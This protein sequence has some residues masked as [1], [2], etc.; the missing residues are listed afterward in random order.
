M[1]EH[2]E[3]MTSKSYSYSKIALISFL[4]ALIAAI[5][6]TISGFG[7][8]LKIWGLGL[9]FK[10]LTWGAY[11]SMFGI[12]ISILGLYFSRPSKNIRGLGY[13]V[14]G[15]LLSIAVTSTALFF[16]NR[17]KSAPPIHDISTDTVKP[18]KFK[19]VLPMRA[20]YPNKSTYAGPKTAA[21][22]H[23]Y[24]PDIKPLYLKQKPSIAYHKALQ[25]AHEMNGGKL[26]RPIPYRAELKQHQQFHGSDLKM[27]L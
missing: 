14:V 22:Q 12:L 25:A 8:N 11:L 3:D 6:F 4:V 13:A 20:K 24:Y 19:A 27:I 10:L 21:L 5:M 23:K 26:M 2:D 9:A 16:Y 7:Y 18:P 17:A 15:L 1:D